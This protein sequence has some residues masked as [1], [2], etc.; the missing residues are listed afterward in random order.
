TAAPGK[1]GAYSLN[2]GEVRLKS[3]RV[4][5]ARLRAA[6]FAFRYPDWGTAAVEL[7]DRWRKR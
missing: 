4:E 1:H 5:P 3:R 6:G 7:I 2:V